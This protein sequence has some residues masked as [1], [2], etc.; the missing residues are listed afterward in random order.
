MVEDKPKFVVTEISRRPRIGQKA[1]LLAEWQIA[2]RRIDP[3][4][5]V[6]KACSRPWLIFNWLA[7]A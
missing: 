3:V 1:R 4:G 6:G 7:A 2:G 5:Q